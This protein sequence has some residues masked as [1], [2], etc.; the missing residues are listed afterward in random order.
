MTCAGCASTGSSHA[1]RTLS[2][3]RSPTPASRTRCSSPGCTT[4]SCAP[5]WPTWPAPAS[6]TA[7][8]PQP[9]APT[10][11]PSTASPGKPAS[12]PDPHAPPAH[13]P[14]LQTR[15]LT[16]NLRPRSPKLASPLGASL[17]GLA[18]VDSQCFVEFRVGQRPVRG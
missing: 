12:P 10:P 15:D 2:A 8:S 3:T 9:P 7:T 14:G 5:A 18:S 6:A 17:Q 11:P 1:S 13:Y 16:Q 4:G